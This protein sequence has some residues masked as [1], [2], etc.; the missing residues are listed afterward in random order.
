[1]E[2]KIA[3]LLLLLVLAHSEQV[4][5][6]ILYVSTDPGS[7][8]NPTKEMQSS[9]RGGRMIYIKALGHSPDPTDNFIFVGTTNCKIPSDGVTD[10][11]IS[12]ET[13]DPEVNADLLNN[14]VTLISYK[15]TT[16]VTTSWPNTI[17]YRASVT[18]QL[19]DVF[20][21]AGFAGSNVNFYGVHEITDLG[22]GLRNMG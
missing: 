9:L 12:C 17:Y 8:P 2:I 11:F 6:Q 20:P 7:P 1:M 19:R 22:D 18:P 5:L 14:P 4:P 16:S 21:S 15:N 13:G 10:T 3:F